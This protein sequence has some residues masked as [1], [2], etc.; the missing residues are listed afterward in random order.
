MPIDTPLKSELPRPTRWTRPAP[1]AFRLFSSTPIQVTSNELAPVELP[2]PV[3]MIVTSPSTV[4]IAPAVGLKIETPRPPGPRPVPV[5]VI[6][7]LPVVASVVLLSS[8]P[9]SLIAALEPPVPVIAMSPPPA[10]M[11]ALMISMPREPAAVPPGLATNVTGAPFEASRGP[12]GAS[13]EQLR[14][15][16]WLARTSIALPAAPLTVTESSVTVLAS[17]A[18][19][20]NGAV[21]P[22][23]PEN[24]ALPVVVTARSNGPSTVRANATAPVPALTLVCAASVTASP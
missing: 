11:L 9:W 2:A 12:T 20:R 22:V 13:P 17:I 24:V 7:P 1:L 16:F 18:K 21:P 3:P 15:M 4:V 5:S 6:L 19:R 10:S 8:M 14:Q 23:A